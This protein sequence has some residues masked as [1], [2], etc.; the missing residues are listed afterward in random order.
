MTWQIVLLLAFVL[1]LYIAADAF[2]DV[3]HKISTGARKLS[4][5]KL[6][7]LAGAI[8]AIGGFFSGNWLRIGALLLASGAGVAIVV[9]YNGAIRGAERSKTE[10]RVAHQ[11]TREADAQAGL[12]QRVTVHIDNLHEQ[13]YRTRRTVD[14]AHEDIRHAETLD[15]IFAAHAAAVAS[16]RDAADASHRAFLTDYGSALAA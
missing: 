7:A 9:S 2:F 14:A 12:N 15:D 6:S 5:P 4:L 10:T 11:E 13:S 1:F 3:S 8:P 16:L